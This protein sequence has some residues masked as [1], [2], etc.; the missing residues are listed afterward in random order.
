MSWKRNIERHGQYGKSLELRYEEIKEHCLKNP[1]D[2]SA[3]QKLKLFKEFYLRKE[4]ELEL[5]RD[6]GNP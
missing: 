3:K 5:T 4:K 1:S 2:K 6:K